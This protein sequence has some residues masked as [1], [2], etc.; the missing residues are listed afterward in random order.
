MSSLVAKLCFVPDFSASP[1][2]FSSWLLIHCLFVCSLSIY[3]RVCSTILYVCLFLFIYMSNCL[4][5]SFLIYQLLYFYGQF[6][7]VLAV[8]HK[9]RT[10][11]YL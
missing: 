6:V 11:K 10:G 3:L 9:K 1:S 7:I 2:F 5:L 4:P 8:L